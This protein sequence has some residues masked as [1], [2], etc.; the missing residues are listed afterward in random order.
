MVKIHIFLLHQ[1]VNVN[2]LESDSETYCDT[3]TCYESGGCATISITLDTT[4]F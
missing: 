3:I 1:N 2:D 4:L